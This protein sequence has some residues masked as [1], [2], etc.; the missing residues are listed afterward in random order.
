MHKKNWLTGKQTTAHQFRQT[1]YVPVVQ[2]VKQLV[3]QG[4]KNKKVNIFKKDTLQDIYIVYVASDR[5]VWLTNIN[6]HE[7]TMR[8][9][10]V[11]SGFGI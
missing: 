6:D 7:L 8:F 5:S 11:M 9:G 1:W 4:T 3:E 10:I 2:L